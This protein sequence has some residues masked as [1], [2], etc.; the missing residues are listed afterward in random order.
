VQKFATYILNEDPGT[1]N[2]IARLNWA[3]NALANSAL[4]VNAYLPAIL[5]NTTVQTDLGAIADA[6]LQTV[7]ETSCNAKINTAVGYRDYYILSVNPD[8]LRRLQVAVSHSPPISSV[9]L[10]RL[11]ITRAATTGPRARP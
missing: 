10:L 1:A 5:Q 3:N 8:F 4:Q 7:V 11:P 9:R 6:D 2:H